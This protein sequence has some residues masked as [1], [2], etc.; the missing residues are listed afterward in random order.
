VVQNSPPRE[1][2]FDFAHGRPQDGH[3]LSLIVSTDN[4]FDCSPDCASNNLRFSA[5]HVMASWIPIAA[6]GVVEKDPFS[7]RAGAHLA[8]FT[9]MNGSLREA[10][11]LARGI[12]SIH[13]GFVLGDPGFG[14][15]DGSQN[16]KE[17]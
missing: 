13:I 6:A 16:E 15:G 10:V 2:A 5:F 4:Y 14:V 9:D 8:I 3:S 12:Q 17:N 1:T 11:R 7:E